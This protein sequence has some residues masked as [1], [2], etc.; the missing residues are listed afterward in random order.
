MVDNKGLVR[1]VHAAMHVTTWM[2]RPAL[3][4]RLPIRFLAFIAAYSFAPASSHHT[5]VWLQGPQRLLLLLF[6]HMSLCV[7]TLHCSVY[8]AVAELAVK[9]FL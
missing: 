6:L 7:R 5:I 2:V 9:L 4:A 1:A 8:L 3:H